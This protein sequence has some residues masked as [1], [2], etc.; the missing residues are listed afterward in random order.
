MNK[1]RA[2]GYLLGIT[3]LEYSLKPHQEIL[4]ATAGYAVRN[5]T[6]PFTSRTFMSFYDDIAWGIGKGATHAMKLSGYA[7]AHAARAGAAG[8]R[9]AGSALLRTAGKGAT[10]LLK[11]AALPIWVAMEVVQLHKD[12]Q[13]GFDSPEWQGNIWVWTSD[14]VFA[15]PTS[16]RS[17]YQRLAQHFGVNMGT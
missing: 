14:L 6:V 8:G 1:T 15:P 11:R 2:F 16:E 13:H 5:K 10:H 9:A 12:A 17:A 3:G 4:L 7:T